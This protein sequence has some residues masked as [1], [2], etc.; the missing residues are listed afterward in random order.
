MQV[1]SQQMNPGTYIDAN[2]WAQMQAQLNKSLGRP[3]RP[4]FQSQLGPGGLIREPYQLQD[5]LNRGYL[6]QMRTDALR[7][8]GEQSQWRQLMEQNVQRQA[9]EAMA[10]GQAQAS[11]AMSNLAMRG[12]LRG[13]AAERLAAQGSQNALQA[14]QNVLGQRLQLDIQDE[15][16]RMQGLQNLG[17]AELQSAQF[18]QGT[19]QFNI[20]TSLNELLQ[21]RANDI[22]AYNE[23]MRAWAAERTARATPSGGGG[24]KK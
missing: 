15:A 19:Q 12:G 9:G 16:N 20:Q 6:E 4:E 21:Q 8:P 13:G 14:G 2:V 3:D 7:Q 11:N 18:G 22:N 5:T 1:N 10:R 24:G 23:E 17:S